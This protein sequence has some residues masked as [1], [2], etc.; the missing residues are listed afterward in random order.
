M[1]HLDHDEPV[2]PTR[3]IDARLHRVFPDETVANDSRGARVHRLLD[4]EPVR[5]RDVR[6]LEITQDVAGFRE[7]PKDIEATREDERPSHLDRIDVWSYGCGELD[8]PLRVGHVERQ[9]EAVGEPHRGPQKENGEKG[10]FPRPDMAEP[11]SKPS[12]IRRPPPSPR[13]TRPSTGACRS[14]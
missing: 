11:L 5:V 4:D 7:L 6:D 14:A 9:D 8:R 13:P 3:G 1:A 12:G 10:S 2:V